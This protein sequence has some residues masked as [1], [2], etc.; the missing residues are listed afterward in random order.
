[1]DPTANA[2][3]NTEHAIRNSRPALTILHLLAEAFIR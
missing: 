1:M 2:N 3:S